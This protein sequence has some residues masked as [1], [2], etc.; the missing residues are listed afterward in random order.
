MEGF[1]FLWKKDDEPKKNE[2]KGIYGGDPP[3]EEKDAAFKQIIDEDYETLYNGW[4]NNKKR[5]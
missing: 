1:D 4:F 2:A 5:R 3:R